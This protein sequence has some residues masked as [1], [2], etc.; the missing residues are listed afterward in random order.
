MSAPLSSVQYSWVRTVCIDPPPH[1]MPK[2]NQLGLH[3]CLYFTDLP[4][5]IQRHVHST[6]S[7]ED[8]QPVNYCLYTVIQ[9]DL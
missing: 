4:L 9:S 8:S 7:L 6:G 5:L 2:S 1:L 3:E